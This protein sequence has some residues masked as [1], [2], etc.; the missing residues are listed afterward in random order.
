MALFAVSTFAVGAGVVALT[1]VPTSGKF[2]DS[3][4]PA[5]SVTIPVLV[6]R[7][8]L[9][10]NPAPPHVALD[11]GQISAQPDVAVPPEIKALPVIP[12]RASR[13]ALHR[14]AVLHKK[15]SRTRKHQSLR[16]AALNH[17]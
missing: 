9:P 4:P 1:H 15:I 10:E 17:P 3:N 13:P 2:A 6:P 8:A 11:P 5:P 7:V 16:S 14:H 12:H